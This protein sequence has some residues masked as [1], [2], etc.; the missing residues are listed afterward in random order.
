MGQSFSWEANSYSATRAIFFILWNWP[1]HCSLRTS[2]PLSLSWARSI[3]SMALILFLQDPFQYCTP[4]YAQ[5][6]ELVCLPQAS[7]QN[8][9]YTSPIRATCPA[10]LTWYHPNNIWWGVQ[11]GVSLIFL[12]LITLLMYVINLYLTL[13]GRVV[14]LKCQ[15]LIYIK[16][17]PFTGP[18]WP[19]G[20]VEV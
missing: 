16:S 4:I 5:V 19:R 12:K 17:D 8:P 18:V 14:T 6:F 1:F 10:H 13:L 2:R 7:H 9:L 15:V 20:W 11:N 3:Q